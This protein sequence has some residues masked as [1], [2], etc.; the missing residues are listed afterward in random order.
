MSRTPVG[1]RLSPAYRR[2]RLPTRRTRVLLALLGR[3]WHTMPV[4]RLCSRGRRGERGDHP[5]CVRLRP[6]ASSAT[7]ATRVVGAPGPLSC[8]ES[9]VGLV[10]NAPGSPMLPVQAL[11]HPPLTSAH[12]GANGIW[13]RALAEVPGSAPARRNRRGCRGGGGRQPCWRKHACEE[14][15]A[16]VVKRA[17]PGQ[18]PVAR[19]RH[20]GVAGRGRGAERRHARAR[21]RTA[22]RAFR[23][24]SWL[25]DSRS[26]MEVDGRCRQSP[27][28]G[29]SRRA[30]GG[31]SE[32]RLSDWLLLDSRVVDVLRLS[33]LI[34]VILSSLKLLFFNDLK[35]A[36]RF[37]DNVGASDPGI[38][39]ERQAF[40]LLQTAIN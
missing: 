25:R 5:Q 27:N 8:A 22:S 30:R 28:T 29:K 31:S 14:G 3:S 7:A 20:R 39:S 15:C 37:S 9:S 1:E 33:N 6:H 34:L 38:Q 36:W 13:V 16:S 4:F 10:S 2:P 26:L 18:V 32:N 23:A 21:H 11:C 24:L 12:R 40:A 17:S 35:K 19:R